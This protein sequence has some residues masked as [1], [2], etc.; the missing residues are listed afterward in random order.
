MHPVT[1]KLFLLFISLCFTVIVSAQQCIGSFGDPVVYQ[2][3]GSGTGPG[4][5]LPDT[6]KTFY[7]TLMTTALPTASIP[8]PTGFLAPVMHFPKHG[9]TCT[10]IIPVTPTVI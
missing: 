3:F 5:P 9:I 4:K 10:P 7:R 6:T 1:K 8:L 2:N